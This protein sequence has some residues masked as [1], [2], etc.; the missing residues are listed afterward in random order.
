MRT[1]T[2]TLFKAVKLKKP[3]GKRAWMIQRR[4][5]GTEIHVAETNV[6]NLLIKWPGQ[7]PKVR[8]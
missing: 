2:T 7:L 8:V 1:P 5:H 4:S 6:R 3:N